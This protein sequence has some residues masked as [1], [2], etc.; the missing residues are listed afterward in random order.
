VYD[1][2]ILCSD[3][4]ASF[5]SWDDYA[6]EIFFNT[7]CD[8]IKQPDGTEVGGSYDVVDEHKLTM[9]FISLAWR[10]QVT[11]HAMFSGMRLGHYE[12]KLKMALQSNEVNLIP[13]F[14]VV[15]SKFDSDLSEGFMGPSKLRIGGVNGYRVGFSRHSCWVKF[16]KRPFP[17]PFDKSALSNGSPLRILY[18]NFDNSPE[19][20]AMVQTV[21]EDKYRG[22]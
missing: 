11:E 1:A 3:C 5:S 14:D 7:Q 9:F 10:M 22:S 15:I 20:K 19:K 16:D 8:P 12:G 2:N 21:R 6:H 4:E 17:S 13:E 18:R